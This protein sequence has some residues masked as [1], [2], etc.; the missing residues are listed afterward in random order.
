M[1]KSKWTDEMI[2]EH[3]DTHWYLT[4]SDMCAL[5]GRSRSDVMRVLMGE[6]DK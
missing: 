4:I 1:K 5:S 2:L 3:Y 6:T